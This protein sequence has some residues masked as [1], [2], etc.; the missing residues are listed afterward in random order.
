M[1]TRRMTS[2]ITL[3]AGQAPAWNTAEPLPWGISGPPPPRG[4]AECGLPAFLC[5]QG[6]AACAIHLNTNAPKCPERKGL[7]YHFTDRKT[8]A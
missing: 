5:T 6:S 4:Y 1:G 8:E 7:N 3:A 2:V